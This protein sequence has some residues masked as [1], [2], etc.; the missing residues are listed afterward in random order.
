[1]ATQL[2]GNIVKG[3]GGGSY[4]VRRQI[5]DVIRNLFSLRG[6]PV[7]YLRQ[8][9]ISQ[10]Y[11]RDH[12]VPFIALPSTVILSHRKATHA[13]TSLTGAVLRATMKVTLCRTGASVARRFCRQLLWNMVTL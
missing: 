3:G 5:C 12:V 4:Y 7:V 11:S 8:V 13:G 9:F 2:E 1:M 6:F 10:T